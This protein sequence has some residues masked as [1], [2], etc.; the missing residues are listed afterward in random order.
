MFVLT[1]PSGMK[2]L[3]SYR[4]F[5]VSKPL[6]SSSEIIGDS[7]KNIS[8]YGNRKDPPYN[9]VEDSPSQSDDLSV[10]IL[11]SNNGRERTVQIGLEQ[12]IKNV[13]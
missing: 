3:E 7:E 11:L 9:L 2:R 13:F 4:T 6:Q 1:V 10:T 8:L 5:Y 12:T